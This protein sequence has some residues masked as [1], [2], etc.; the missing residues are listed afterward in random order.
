M[1]HKCI[2]P[3]ETEATAVPRERLRQVLSPELLSKAKTML[4][5]NQS[6]SC[7]DTTQYEAPAC[8]CLSSSLM[9][10]PATQTD[11]CMGQPTVCFAVGD[12]VDLGLQGPSV[13]KQLTS[14]IE[15]TSKQGMQPVLFHR[16]NKE[17]N[18]GRSSCSE[19]EAI[20]HFMAAACS[21]RHGHH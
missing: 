14:N 16:N 6:L 3:S 9:M 19:G 5:F 10:S 17:G 12:I 20:A 2:K 4:A 13:A 1:A 21:P 7:A 18:S 8:Y 11:T 15:L